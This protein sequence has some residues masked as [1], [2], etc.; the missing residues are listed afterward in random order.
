MTS[1]GLMHSLRAD[2]ALGRLSPVMDRAGELL[3]SRRFWWAICILWAGL[4]AWVGRNA[5]NP[6]GMSYLDMASESLHRGPSELISGYWSPGYPAILALALR[7]VHPSAGFEFPLIHFVNFLIFIA[8][9]ACFT[10]FTRSW[11]ERDPERRN[12]NAYFIPFSFGLFLWV[13]TEFISTDSVSPDML[14][15][16]IVFLAA[17]I[18]CRISRQSLG[19]KEFALLGAVLGLGYYAK[20]AMLPLALL[21]LAT[22]FVHPIWP[23]RDRL[24]IA[25]AGVTCLLMASPLIALISLRTGRLSTGETGPL[26]YAW[27]V[28]GLAPQIGWNSD[29]DR[30]GGSPLHPPQALLTKPNVLAFAEPVH[31]TYPLWYDPSYWYAG[32][33]IRFDVRQQIAA[34]KANWAVLY[35]ML[36]VTVGLATGVLMFLVA[37]KRKEPPA[38][39]GGNLTW[40]VVWSAEAFLMYLAVHLEPR[41][42][43][44]FYVLFWL[45][46]YRTISNR[47]KPGLAMLLMAVVLATLFVPSSI[48]L[49]A[50]ARQELSAMN[51]PPDDIA[52]ANA[53][54]AAGIQAGDG[55]ASVGYSFDVYFVH[56][57]RARVISQVLDADAFWKMNDAERAALEHRLEA[58]GVKAIVAR[59]APGANLPRGWRTAGHGVAFVPLSPA[60]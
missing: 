21:L 57:L 45:A 39:A 20:A 43:G 49:A 36:L 7:L 40:A 25:V 42:V 28:N 22:L 29:A 41:F 18:C 14:V 12:W 9:L 53:L 10:F 2:T 23:G 1:P 6:D 19:W 11:L 48:V 44:A 56:H 50:M 37:T 27:Y 58:I 59:N 13:T 16:A 32:A 34:L 31:G 47:V 52:I 5:M 54:R 55:L 15:A 38:V 26:N 24:R 8:T 35:E 46:V 51:N 4:H 17:G 30:S 60:K 3:V 33:K